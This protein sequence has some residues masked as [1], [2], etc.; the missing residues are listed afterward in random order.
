MQLNA[1][2]ITITDHDSI[3]TGDFQSVSGTDYD[4]R[5]TRNLG[6]SLAKISNS[7]YDDNFCITKG[8]DQTLAFIAR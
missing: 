6:E 1:D 4:F 3:P 5:V 2:R 8:T 7:G